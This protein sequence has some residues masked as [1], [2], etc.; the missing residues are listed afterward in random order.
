MGQ[1]VGVTGFEPA[2]SWSQTTRS[3]K[4]SYTP[5]WRM[6][7]MHAPASHQKISVRPVRR[8]DRSTKLAMANPSHGGLSYTP[9][10]RMHIMHAHVSHQRISVR[11]VAAAS[12]SRGA[13]SYTANRC[14]V[15]T[16]AL[17]PPIQMF[18]IPSGQRAHKLSKIA[19]RV[20]DLL[21]G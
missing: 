8:G 17:L 6:H 7:I 12:P 2:T 10:W 13:P 18:A 21:V 20:R 16:C 3:T 4:L 9:R 1:V 15:S 19:H 14:G 5:R 11:P